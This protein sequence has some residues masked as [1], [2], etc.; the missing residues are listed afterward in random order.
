MSVIVPHLN[1]LQRLSLCVEALNSQSFEREAFEIIVA[2]NGSDCGVAAVESAAVGARVISVLEKGAAPARNGALAL[3]RGRFLAFTDSDCVPDPHWLAEGRAAL[4]TS[5]IV[6]GNIRLT[7]SNPTRPTAVEAFE[8]IFAFDN[9]RYVE[10]LGFSVTANLFAKR[11]VYDTIAGFQVGIPEDM[12]WCRRARR[13]GYRLSYAPRAVVAH[14]ARH[15]MPE[16][17]S[18]W[19]R[20]TAEAYGDLRLNGGNLWTWIAKSAAVLVSP[21]YDAAKVL[22]SRRLSNS[23]PRL[24]ALMVLFRIRALRAAWMLKLLGRSRN[25]GNSDRLPWISASGAKPPKPLLGRSVG[26]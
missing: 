25:E 18:K 4:E 23:A 10:R 19:R 17:I 5:D 15:D 14:P 11:A 13:A 2:D 8:L 22:A 7:V 21:L 6:G 3:A 24:A 1:D 20:L 26:Y 16:L 12:D 9:K